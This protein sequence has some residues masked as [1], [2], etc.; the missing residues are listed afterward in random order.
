LYYVP[1]IDGRED[2]YVLV[3]EATLAG[4]TSGVVESL[5]CTPF[6]I[7]KVRHQISS[8]SQIKPTI[9]QTPTPLSSKLLPGYS[10]STKAF[11]ST[12]ELL[13]ILSPKHPD[14]LGA[15]KTYPWMLTGSGRPP[16]ASEVKGLKSVVCLEGWGA[17][18]RGIRPGIFR[19]SIFGGFFF[20]TWQFLHEVMLTWKSLSINPPPRLIMS[21]VYN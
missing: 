3:S 4:I 12:V 17:L 20:G 5:T 10:P 11:S 2:N 18:W 8:S 1:L 19:D 6:E 21:Y 7:L 16:L 14:L 15:L 9:T 13:S